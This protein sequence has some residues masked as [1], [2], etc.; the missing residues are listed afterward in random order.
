MID[1]QAAKNRQSSPHQ[2][3]CEDRPSLSTE[4]R[5][6]Q[7]QRHAFDKDY[8]DLNVSLLRVWHAELERI[9]RIVRLCSK[10]RH[11]ESDKR[12]QPFPASWYEGSVLIGGCDISW[13]KHHPGDAV[14]MLVVLECE[15]CVPNASRKVDAGYKIVYESFEHIHVDIP[16]Q[17][18]FLAFRESPAIVTLVKQLQKNRPDLVPAFLL[19]DG[20]GE[21][22]P[23]GAGL[24]CHIGVAT[25]I[26][27][28]GIGKSLLHV[29]GLT[30]ERVKVQLAATTRT[31]PSSSPFIAVPPVLKLVGDSGRTWGAA[32]C[33]APN[34]SQPI[35][36]SIG[37]DVTLDE[38][39]CVVARVTTKY[40]VPSPIRIADI[41]SREELRRIGLNE[42][43]S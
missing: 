37:Y 12:E 19:V 34:S 39:L 35:F 9:G 14:S 24:A 16:Y 31:T 28:I 18:G 10:R 23:S 17:A 27:T 25:G 15:P 6:G 21:L 40:R 8:P 36:V 33:F 43:V 3:R 29:D 5:L 22:H 30:K 42:S 26:P 7:F 4:H 2:T 13:D 11:A 20:N 41:R 1:A 38:S 32:A